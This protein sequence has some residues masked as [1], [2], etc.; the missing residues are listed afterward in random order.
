MRP[1]AGAPGQS[2]PRSY[3]KLGHKVQRL[4]VLFMV[5]GLLVSWMAGTAQAAER[6]IKVVALGDSLTAGFQLRGSAAFPVQLEQALKAKGLAVDV[7][8]AGVSGD[9]ASG[10]LARLDWSVPAGTDA[11][12]LELGANDMLRGVD[13][14]VTR[15]ALA[16]IVRRLKARNIEVLLCGMRAAPNFGPDYARA[17]DAIYP[18]LAAANDLVFYPFFLDGIVT[19]PKL[20]ISD[21]LHPTGE[22]VARIVSGILPK[23]EAVLA[24]VRAKPAS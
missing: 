8:N 12:I 9:T 5:A 19:D 22:G 1:D 15:E 17:F 6:T 14:K 13:P 24:R 2:A 20:N 23:V 7:A 16:E 11:V 4:A 18:E 10:G 21:G 3:G